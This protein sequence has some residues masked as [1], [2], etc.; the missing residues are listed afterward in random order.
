M[1]LKSKNTISKGFIICTAWTKNLRCPWLRHAKQKQRWK[2][3]CGVNKR[4][5]LKQI[6][7]LF[8]FLFHHAE[9]RLNVALFKC[10]KKNL[11]TCRCRYLKKGNEGKWD[12]SSNLQS[13]I[14][15]QNAMYVSG[16]NGCFRVQVEC[17][18]SLW[19]TLAAPRALTCRERTGCSTSS[20]RGISAV[21]LFLHWLLSCISL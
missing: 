16:E 2:F 17:W 14:P 11:I 6:K 1:N 7:C 13:I 18:I 19:I 3:P 21:N 15:R 8:P 5:W 9:C 20:I 4:N 10:K 12:F